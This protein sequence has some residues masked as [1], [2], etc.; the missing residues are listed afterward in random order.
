MGNV[1]ARGR[2]YVEQRCP[3]L[4]RRLPPV[5]LAVVGAAALAW[6][7]GRET[8]AG[9]VVGMSF[10]PLWVL[11]GGWR[12]WRAPEE[13]LPQLMH[14]RS[15]QRRVCARVAVSMLAGAGVAVMLLGYAY[16][17]DWTGVQQAW[18]RAAIW[19]AVLSPVPVLLDPLVWR[20]WTRPFRRAVRSAQALMLLQEPD[21]FRKVSPRRRP[22]WGFDPDQ[23]FC[24]R[25]L[26]VGRSEPHE[27]RGAPH[28]CWGRSRNGTQVGVSWDGEAAL[29]V[30][31][32]G[33]GTDVRIPID[34]VA[35]LVC[36]SESTPRQS[37]DEV[38]VLDGAGRRLATLPRGT[39]GITDLSRVAAAAGVRFADYELGF[40][41]GASVLTW[42]LFPRAKTH[43]RI[44][45]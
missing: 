29:V 15:R 24:G 18:T 40:A 32:E 16:E 4:P 20:A 44:T 39:L 36:V 45:A 28:T 6:G 41:E 17:K 35:E 8:P 2:A 22:A 9:V 10:L 5:L 34:E 42:R 38:L 1:W 13:G 12:V 11:A 3:K 21:R 43:R 23:G 19:L 27:R 25:P 7:A 30:R 33:A 14:W 31:L 37:I 26:P